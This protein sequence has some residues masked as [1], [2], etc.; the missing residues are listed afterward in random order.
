MKKII[1]I[2]VVLALAVSIGACGS[3]KTVTAPAQTQTVTTPT[4][5]AGPLKASEETEADTQRQAREA[6]TKGWTSEEVD[7]FAAG[8]AAVGVTGEQAHCITRRVASH[9]TPAEVVALSTTE[10]HEMGAKYGQGCNE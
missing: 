9:M 6:A 3:T 8:L 7:E 10:A 2:I 5:V 4:P 1:S